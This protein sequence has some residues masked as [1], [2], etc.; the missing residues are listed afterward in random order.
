[1]RAKAI[2]DL[3]AVQFVNLI[4]DVEA[5]A[6]GQTAPVRARVVQSAVLPDDPFSPKPIRDAALGL[7]LGLML[8]VGL[9]VARHTLDRSVK[10]AEALGELAQA[11]VLGATLLESSVRTRP[12][13][14][15]DAPRSPLAEAYRQLRTNVQYVDIDHARKLIVVTSSVAGEGKSTTTCNLAIALAQGGARVLLVE[16]DLRRPRAADYLGMDN[17]VGLT[18]VL[19]GQVDLDLAIQPWNEG[20]I[21]YSWVRGGCRRTRRSCWPLGRCARSSTSSVPA[22]TSCSSTPRR[23]CRLRTRQCW[24]RSATERCSSPGTAK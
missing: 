4:D 1:M 11:P 19:T 7:I 14:M 20:L 12:L 23:H 21:D 17:T 5:P 22:T 13:V 15:L 10:S 8:G 9:A 6:V 24:R 16:A 3:V 18:T 2:A